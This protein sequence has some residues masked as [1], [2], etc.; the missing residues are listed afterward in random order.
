MSL[1]GR[2]RVYKGQRTGTAEV[3]RLG[4]VLILGPTKKR[5]SAPQTRGEPAPTGGPSPCACPLARVHGPQEE[6]RV[7]RAEGQPEDAA[8]L[9]SSCV[10]SNLRAPE[11]GRHVWDTEATAGPAGTEPLPAGSSHVQG[12]DGDRRRGH[13]RSRRDLCRQEVRATPQGSPWGPQRRGSGRDVGGQHVQGPQGVG[14]SHVTC[15]NEQ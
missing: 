1:E 8:S 11:C 4:S 3:T 12:E 2:V 7:A 6:G 5:R 9:D 15:R 10:A 14:D 13:F